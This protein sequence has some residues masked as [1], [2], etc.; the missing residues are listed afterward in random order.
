MKQNRLLVI[1]QTPPPHHGQ[2]VAIQQLLSATWPDFEIVH[3]RMTYSRSEAAIGRFSVRKVWHLAALVVK[4]IIQLRRRR[5]TILYYPP[6]GPSLVPLL[7]DVAF[8]MLVRPFACT[9]VFHFHAGGT[10]EYVKTKPWLRRLARI[11][12]AGADAAIH[13][14]PSAPNDGAYFRAKRV[15]CVPNGLDVP[16]QSGDSA[17][18]GEPVRILFVGHHT[19]RKGI[20]LVIRTAALLHERGVRFLVHT[21]GAWLTKRERCTCEAMVQDFGLSGKVVFLGRLTGANKWRE[22]ANADVF[23][24]PTYYEGEGMPLVLLEA[25]A[26]ALPVIASRWRSIPDVVVDGVTGVLCD[27]EEPQAFAEA[28]QRVFADERY[29]TAMGRAAQQR[30]RECY[31]REKHLDRMHEAFTI[32]ADS[33]GTSGCEVTPAR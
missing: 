7:R 15:L 12:Y 20:R 28:L 29:R 14:G 9:T 1:G 11:A 13:L 16:L 26:Y 19:E 5:D 32:V 21:V 2:A 6:A 33:P 3:I 17:V 30:Y 27:P 22:Y 23:F 18:R 10:S 24:F 4:A 31:T 25:M 8:L